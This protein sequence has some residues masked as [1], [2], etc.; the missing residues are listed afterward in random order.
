MAIPS[1]SD[2]KTYIGKL[3]DN[4]YWNFNFTKLVNWLTD[5][6]ADLSFQSFVASADSSMG[7]AKITN[8]GDP[9]LATDAANKGYVD[10]TAIPMGYLYGFKIDINGTTP[11]TDLDIGIGTCQSS[12]NTL[13][14]INSVS[15]TKRASTSWSAGTGNG[16]LDAGTFAASTTYYLFAIAKADGTSDILCSTS[17]TNPALPTGYTVY[18]QIGIFTTDTNIHI[19]HVFTNSALPYQLEYDYAN[20]VEKAYQTSYTAGI[21]GILYAEGYITSTITTIT[22]DSVIFTIH[23]SSSQGSIAGG[24]VPVSAGQV[25]Y[26]DGQPFGTGSTVAYYFIPQKIK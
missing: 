4:T 14:I 17:A 8:L 16:M 19:L 24:F 21:N 1:V 18:R 23:I 22:I 26:F 6:T 20:R 2:L 3:I 11:N 12:A 13:A 7:N 9:T 10:N 25:Y 5:S 15:T